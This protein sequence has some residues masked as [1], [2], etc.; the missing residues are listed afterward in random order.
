[1]DFTPEFS[2]TDTE[3][4]LLTTRS[5]DEVTSLIRP[6]LE[7]HDLSTG[8]GVELYVLDL[9][10]SLSGRLALKLLSSPTHVNEALGLAMA[11]LFL[12]QY[13]LLADRCVLPL[14]A[15]VDLFG[16]AGQ[17]ATIEDDVSLQRGDLL[18]VACD[19]GSRALHFYVI[20]VKWRSDLS[21]LSAY[22]SLRQQ[23]E[24]QLNQSQESLRRLF[25][26]R[27]QSPDRIDRQVQSKQLISL[28][29]FYLDRSRRYGLI[30]PEAAEGLVPF[31]ESLDQGYTLEC[32]G[33]GL[34]FDQSYQGIAQ[35][36]EH[37]PARQW[38]APSQPAPRPRP[39]P[40]NDNRRNRAAAAGTRACRA[41]HV[42]A[43][44]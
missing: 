27:F 39:H 6:A 25:D 22:V 44:R 15:H 14:D 43:R 28:L 26:P 16:A 41:R 7:E 5:A 11:R 29:R 33:A 32:A 13:G 24:T 9:L 30:R 4:L 23:I 18:L 1:L 8:E 37:A 21:D 2:H 12:E 36:E 19:P 34:I 40:P 10:R 20:E 35:E 17:E 38:A 42:D 3:R 31:V